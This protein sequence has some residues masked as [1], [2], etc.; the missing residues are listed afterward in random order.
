LVV[1]RSIPMTLPAIFSSYRICELSRFVIFS[2]ASNRPIAP[3]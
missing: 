3:R 1:P 2:I